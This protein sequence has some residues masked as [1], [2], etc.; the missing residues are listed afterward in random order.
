MKNIIF[1]LGGVIFNIDY[2]LTSQAFTK[3][4]LQGFDEVYSQKKQE[5]FFDDFEKG[6]ISPSHFRDEVRKYMPAPVSDEEIDQ[7]WN[8][9]L[10]G[11]PAKRYDWLKKTGEQFRIFLLS[12]T[13]LIHVEALS[14]MI[15]VAGFGMNNFKN[16]FEKV[17][18]SCTMGMRKPD[19]EIFDFV[20][21]ENRLNREET[22]FIDDSIQHIQGAAR[23]G[24]KAFHLN[25]DIS[26][27]EV[28]SH[29]S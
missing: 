18:F 27:E 7:A 1:D 6:I 3:L 19:R 25:N 2:H 14:K 17:Y 28:I 23:A 20:V 12:N 22:L 15:D 21:N 9:M 13:N 4:G 24:L 26:V 5:H 10:I 16:L 11:V 8:A 29:K